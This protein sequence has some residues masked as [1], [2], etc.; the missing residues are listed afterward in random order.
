MN[1]A[2]AAC[3]VT[4]AAGLGSILA[5]PVP[6]YVTPT[7]TVPMYGVGM[8]QT[9][10]PPRDAVLD[11]IAKLAERVAAVDAKLDR[12][13]ALVDD[14]PP[15]KAAGQPAD[16]LVAGATK[17]AACHLPDVA[18]AKGGGFRLFTPAGTFAVLTP[19][20][21][22]QVRKRIAT[23]DPSFQMPPPKSGQTL[24]DAE[25]AALVAAFQE[26]P[27]EKVP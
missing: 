13:L 25:R 14:A 6:P 2:I 9:Q 11:A 4:V 16:V 26:V 1:R 3:V 17:C 15:E 20:Q 22:T 8:A 18:E 23:T 24:T 12:L 27:K 21:L 19:R 7:V 10:E 5:G